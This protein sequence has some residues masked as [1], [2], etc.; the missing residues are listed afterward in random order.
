MDKT[1]FIPLLFKK[2][3]WSPF[4]NLVSYLAQRGHSLPPLKKTLQRT[5]M[6]VLKF[7]PTY[8]FLTFR[9]NESDFSLIREAA[10]IHLK[11]NIM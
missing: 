11:N 6:I 5:L 2:Q 3:F 1:N 8:N 4:S 10:F 7:S 9:S